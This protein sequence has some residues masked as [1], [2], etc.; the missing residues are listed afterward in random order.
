M[1]APLRPPV[2]LNRAWLPDD[3]PPAPKP[4]T[5]GNYRMDTRVTRS[6][7]HFVIEDDL[8]CRGDGVQ[9]LLLRDEPE[10]P[11]RS[12]RVGAPLEVTREEIALLLCLDGVLDRAQKAP[13]PPRW[14][15]DLD[16]FEGQ[17]VR[18]SPSGIARARTTDWLALRGGKIVVEPRPG[19]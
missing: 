8:E 19:A 5:G 16:G 11:M 14:A 6:G 18:A 2:C 7:Q 12:M 3:I 9:L 13:A 10:R 4:P 17:V 15:R 1:I